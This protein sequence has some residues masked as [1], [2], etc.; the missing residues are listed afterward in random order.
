[1]CIRDRCKFDAITISD[2]LSYID[3]TKCRL[4]R[5]C[6]EVCP[7]GAIHEVN[8]PARKPKVEKPVEEKVVATPEET[9][10]EA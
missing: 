8:F 7:T 1:M 5:K 6:V 10:A 9:P 4:C 3:H 2:N